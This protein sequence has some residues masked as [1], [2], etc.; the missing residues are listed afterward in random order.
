M[1]SSA[2]PWRRQSS[3]FPRHRATLAVEAQSK[4]R[5]APPIA[6]GT[7]RPALLPPGGGGAAQSLHEIIPRA[8]PTRRRP[9]SSKR[10]LG[11]APTTNSRERNAPRQI[12]LEVV[13]PFPQGK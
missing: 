13:D 8:A 5:Q 3:G 7:K 2:Q 12:L 10:G 11:A 6:V 9:A 4:S 1:L